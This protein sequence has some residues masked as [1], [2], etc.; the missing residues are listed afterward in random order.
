MLNRVSQTTPQFVQ[1]ERIT[2]SE[3]SSDSTSLQEPKSTTAVITEF[4]NDEV[5]QID[6]SRVNNCANDHDSALLSS[7]DHDE[8]RGMPTTAE[9][10]KGSA[11]LEREVDLKADAVAEVMDTRAIVSV[12]DQRVAH[13]R[14]DV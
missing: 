8:M 5:K 6:D 2:G 14:M 10:N 11:Q 12:N 1:E 13:L 7:V 9:A 4:E 3:S